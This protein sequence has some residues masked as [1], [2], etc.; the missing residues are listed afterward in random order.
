MSGKR[1]NNRSLLIAFCLLM[2]SCF[3]A[4]STVQADKLSVEKDSRGKTIGFKTQARVYRSPVSS[5][6]KTARGRLLSQVKTFVASN[7]QALGLSGQGVSLKLGR[8]TRD[9]SGLSHVRSHQ[10][11]RG[12]PVHGQMGIFHM[13]RKGQV[14]SGSIDFI[15][16]ISV[17]TTPKVSREQVESIATSTWKDKHPDVPEGKAGNVR[18]V[19]LPA[20]SPNGADTSRLSLAWIVEVSSLYYNQ[21]PGFKLY[22]DASD[23]KIIRDENSFRSL[24]GTPAQYR[25]VADC[26]SYFLGYPTPKTC[27]YN[28]A[29]VTTPL[30]TPTPTAYVLGRGESRPPRGPFPYNYNQ[31]TQFFYGSQDIDRYYSVLG[32][33]S[34]YMFTEHDRDG[35]NFHGGMV[36]TPV[37]TRAA[38]PPGIQGPLSN[39]YSLMHWD[40]VANPG[41]CPDAGFNHQNGST[42]PQ[43]LFCHD[44][45]SPDVA[46]H[47]YTHSLVYFDI[48]NGAWYYPLGTSYYGQ[49]GALEESYADVFG[50]AVEEQVTGL[51]DWKSGRW[52]DNPQGEYPSNNDPRYRDME[53]PTSVVN[54]YL[55][56]P[57]PDRFISANYYC[58]SS[59]NAGVHHNSTVVSKAFSLL[60][61]GGDF[62]GCHISGIGMLPAQKILYS[63]WLNYFTYNVTFNQAYSWFISA[64]D[65]LYG[66]TNPQYCTE[67]R[68]AM[69]A[70][71]LDQNGNCPQNPDNEQAPGCA[72]HDEG[73]PV[74]TNSIPE[75]NAT[76]FAPGE[77]IW[78][79]STGA[80]PGRAVSVYMQPQGASAPA[81]WSALSGPAAVSATVSSSGSFEALVG[82]AETDGAYDLIVDGNDDGF[83]QPWADTLLEIEIRTPSDGDGLC[84]QGESPSEEISETCFTSPDD[85]GCSGPYFC[86][87]TVVDGIATH[88]CLRKRKLTDYPMIVPLPD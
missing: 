17:D 88:T 42:A 45:F 62:N 26:T 37:P 7:K 43:F 14:Q 84:F 61:D 10:F 35:A 87:A 58:G 2:T 48:D 70:V 13:N 86:G 54:T 22:I 81:R 63:A 18:L 77:H 78:V 53:N 69:Q 52:Q 33:I 56:L 65:A 67:L 12:L 5:R 57:Y 75:M 71:E 60:V 73:T 15:D 11:Y 76:L 36:I 44:E 31:T 38:T 28:A 74:T 25:V 40:A 19:V 6:A 82:L 21:M 24:V 30:P 46:G 68:K 32:T 34:N 16:N 29:A 47:E 27:Y 80:A 66:T 3:A 72:V 83:Y 1:S 8:V 85:C 50:A 59:D 51:Y 41:Y 20:F 49:S 39:I 55:G 23:G 9:K 64:C 79:R 4:S